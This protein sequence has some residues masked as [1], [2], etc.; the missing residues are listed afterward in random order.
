MKN[1]YFITLL[2]ISVI[3]QAQIVD[4]PDA[5]FKYALVNENVVDIDGDEIGDIPVDTN[6]DGEIQES[7]A[8]SVESLIVSDFEIISLEGIQSF[9]YLEKLYCTVNQLTSL[10]ITQNTNLEV[11]ICSWNQIN[12]LNISQNPNLKT[13]AIRGNPISNLDLTQSPN[14]EKLYCEFNLL[15]ELDVTQNLALETLFCGF[16]SLTSLNVSQNIN[17]EVLYCWENQLSELDVSQNINLR[18]IDCES[19]PLSNLNIKNGNNTNMSKMYTYDN[20]NLFCI[21]IDDLDYANNVYCDEFFQDGWCKDDW[22]EYSEFCELGTEDS[23]NISFTIY[24]NPSQNTLFI[25]IQGPIETVKIYNLQGQLIN[26]SFTSSIDVSKLSIG[27]YFVQVTVAG[28]S[29]TKKFVKE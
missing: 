12:N 3:T 24:P 21:Q 17:L 4:I 15:T 27:L 6:N 23:T 16:N 9:I 26:E 13:L 29:E 10:N 25:E 18:I 11:L 19:N 2:L 28:K 1:N 7:E 14:I 22:T 8:E 5:N 20:P